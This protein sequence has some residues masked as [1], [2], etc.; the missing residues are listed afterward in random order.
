M[1][2]YFWR[3]A[4]SAYAC[5]LT[6]EMSIWDVP[7]A[8][9][10]LLKW[11][12]LYFSTISVFQYFVSNHMKYFS[13]YHEVNVFKHNYWKFV[14]KIYNI[15]YIKITHFFKFDFMVVQQTQNNK[16]SNI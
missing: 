2:N 8:W 3:E 13:E 4:W 10:R 11:V 7:L 1:K 12:D 5:D 14:E 6:W 16:S 9:V 15:L